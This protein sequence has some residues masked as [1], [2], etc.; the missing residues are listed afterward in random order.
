MNDASVRIGKE[1]ARFFHI[2][3]ETIGQNRVKEYFI[4][5]VAVQK[6]P[7]YAFCKRGLDVIVALVAGVLC[8]F[9]MLLLALLIRLDSKGSVIFKQERLG[10]DGKPFFIYKFR[11]MYEDAEKDG[12]Q[13]AEEDDARCTRI[14]KLMRKTRLDE[15]PQLWNILV[16]EM[17]LVGPRPERPVFYEE[18]ETYIH[19]FSNRLA[20]KP[21]L[22]G[23]AQVNGGYDL[24][25]EEKIRWDM[26]YIENRS[27]W[28]DVK[29]ILKTVNLVFTHKGAR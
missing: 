16:G 29:C 25:P 4:E 19:G 8:I 18:F 14:G 9:P 15:L 21:G 17:S 1:T 24:L 7:I 28:M 23:Y 20:V 3:P 2:S 26:H 27:M 10:K 12:P 22:T 13:W 6:K 11:S 5:P